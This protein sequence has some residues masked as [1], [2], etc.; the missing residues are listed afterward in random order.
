MTELHGGK[1][2][3]APGRA[4]NADCVPVDPVTGEP[5]NPARDLA[6]V[7]WAAMIPR[8][9]LPALLGLIFGLFP[10]RATAYQVFFFLA[11]GIHLGSSL[12]YLKVKQA[13]HQ[14]A[15]GLHARHVQGS[16][17]GGHDASLRALPWGAQVCD[18]ILFGKPNRHLIVSSTGGK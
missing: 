7:N 12:M 4:I 15:A 5:A 16:A 8:I 18:R 10:A 11:A 14:V 6:L 13:R 3:S 1:T 9:L 2:S 17:S